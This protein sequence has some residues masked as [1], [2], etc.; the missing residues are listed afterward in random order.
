MEVKSVQQERQ[1]DE[2]EKEGEEG[3][4]YHGDHQRWWAAREQQKLRVKSQTRD[5]SLAE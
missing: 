1:E 3:P 5:F 2:E 4:T